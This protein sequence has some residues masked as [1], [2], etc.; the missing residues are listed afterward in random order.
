M[1]YRVTLTGYC[2]EERATRLREEQALVRP[3]LD[4]SFIVHG[5]V[6]REPLLIKST[7]SGRNA[8]GVWEGAR[9]CDS[10]SS[11]VRLWSV[12]T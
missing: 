1:V 8:A 2:T 3:E 6:R 12:M 5:P 7:A 10:S 9:Q 11:Q 4:D